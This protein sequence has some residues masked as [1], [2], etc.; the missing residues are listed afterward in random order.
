MD[1]GRRRP[2]TSNTNALIDE[3]WFNVWTGT[4]SRSCSSNRGRSKWNLLFGRDFEIRPPIF[5]FVTG[6]V[7]RSF[8]CRNAQRQFG[9]KEMKLMMQRGMS[10]LHHS[11]EVEETLQLVQQSAANGLNT[12]LSTDG[13]NF[14]LKSLF[15]YL[16]CYLWIQMFWKNNDG[17]IGQFYM[18]MEDNWEAYSILLIV[19]CLWYNWVI[20]EAF[21]TLKSIYLFSVMP[22]CKL[23]RPSFV[24]FRMT[25]AIHYALDTNIELYERRTHTRHFPT[26]FVIVRVERVVLVGNA[27]AECWIADERRGGDVGHLLEAACL[28]I[29]AIFAFHRGGRGG[30]SGAAEVEYGGQRWRRGFGGTGGG[31]A[32]LG[33]LLACR[34][35]RLQHGEGGGRRR[36][37]L[38]CAAALGHFQIVVQGGHTAAGQTWKK[39][40]ARSL[41]RISQKC[42]AAS[43]RL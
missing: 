15:D 3:W 16:S 27:K 28:L 41:V 23:V 4:Q 18:Y 35:V 20:S 40:G 36:S 43:F 19:Y 32:R 7:K 33:C 30:G 29:E 12:R 11:Y 25:K 24:Q 10:F 1:D 38:G 31:W 9:D 21:M 26:H 14:K 39:L 34:H 17:F 22:A 37:P 2:A 6:A 5:S 13:G 42:S 8:L